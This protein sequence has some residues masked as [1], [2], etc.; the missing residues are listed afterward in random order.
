MKRGVG[1]PTIQMSVK[2]RDF[3]DPLTNLLILTCSF[4]WCRWIFAKF[5]ASKNEKTVEGSIGGEVSPS[6]LNMNDRR[7][8]MANRPK[9]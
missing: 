7:V 3:A 5:S 2:F 6:V 9:W 1:D 4:H 8:N